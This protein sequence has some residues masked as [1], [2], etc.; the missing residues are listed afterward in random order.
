[1]QQSRLGNY[2]KLYIPQAT[3]IL[4]K[5]FFTLLIFLHEL[6]CIERMLGKIIRVA[7]ILMNLKIN[8]FYDFYLKGP[9]LSKKHKQ[10]IFPNVNSFF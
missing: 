8:N 7:Q 9:N 10:M 1:M 2:K 5:P 3:Q 6:C 4:Q